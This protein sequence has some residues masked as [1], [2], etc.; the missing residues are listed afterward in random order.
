M[1]VIRSASIVPMTYMLPVMG[2]CL[3]A[4]VPRGEGASR[5][6][7]EHEITERAEAIIGHK[8]VTTRFLNLL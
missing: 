6:S 5:M 4:D 2:K 3:H 8:S 7:F 1:A